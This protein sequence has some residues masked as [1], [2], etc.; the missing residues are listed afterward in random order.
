MVQFDVATEFREPPKGL[1]PSHKIT[2]QHGSNTYTYWYT[3]EPST[4]R[5][6]DRMRDRDLVKRMHA[7]GMEFGIDQ[8]ESFAIGAERDYHLKRVSSHEFVIKSLR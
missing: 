2:I 3:Q 1:T 5:P 6:F 4:A 8:F 7:K